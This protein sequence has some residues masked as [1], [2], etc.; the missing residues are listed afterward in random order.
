LFR[1][2]EEKDK[3]RQDKTRQDKTREVIIA[4]VIDLGQGKMFLPPFM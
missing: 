1:E 3:T 2:R 4:T